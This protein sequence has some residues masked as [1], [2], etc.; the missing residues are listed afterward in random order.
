MFT[1][2]TTMATFNRSSRC[3]FF[4]HSINPNGDLQYTLNVNVIYFEKMRVSEV[5]SLISCD[6]A[7]LRVPQHIESG[8]MANQI[9][10]ITHYIMAQVKF[11]LLRISRGELHPE[12][13]NDD[14]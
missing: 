11:G 6:D 1:T 7:A 4:D 5:H 12:Q 3:T 9:E 10:C 8:R 14:L 13:A 2:T